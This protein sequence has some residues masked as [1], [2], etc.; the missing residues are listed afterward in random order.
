VNPIHQSARK[1]AMKTLNKVLAALTFAGPLVGIAGQASADPSQRLESPLTP[2]TAKI[3][4]AADLDLT[5]PA[6]IQVLYKRIRGA[7][8][9]LCE[10][11]QSAPWDVKRNLHRRQ[12]FERAVA[13]AVAR[14][15]QPALTA[16]H[17]STAESVASR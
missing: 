12:C 16:L 14:V 10:T 2:D 8:R 3:V 7:A 9:T 15:N 6:D 4:R 13:R 1:N 5:K 17:Q 11:E